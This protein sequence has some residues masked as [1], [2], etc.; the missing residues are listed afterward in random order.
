MTQTDREP[1]NILISDESERIARI[2]EF[3]TYSGV[4]AVKNYD[5]EADIY[6]LSVPKSQY[7]RAVSLLRIYMEQEPDEESEI[8]IEEEPASRPFIG[9][10]EKYKDNYSSAF[11]FLTVGGLVILLL[12]LCGF[13]VLPLPLTWD[14]QPIMVL[15]L[16]AI[17]V[18]FLVIGAVSL[19]KAGTYKEQIGTEE[20]MKSGILKWFYD[21]YTGE[22][23][24][25][26]IE[27]NE[28]GIPRD[29]VLCLKRL[30]LIHDYLLR[31]YPS[32]EESRAD[33]LGETIYQK[34]YE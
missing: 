22:Q 18:I 16:S 9:S 2:L 28:G 4:D 5:K 12:I 34:L 26:T 29:E 19:K 23:I 8:D 24:D 3:L 25:R 1:M 7:D 21:T 33:S 30:A 32:L 20:A 13:H 17:S 6:Q 11:S 15:A 27:A 10:E 14:S 31:E